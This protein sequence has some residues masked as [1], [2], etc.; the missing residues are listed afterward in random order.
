MADRRRA[1]PL[2]KQLQ[3]IAPL[4][5][6]WAVAGTVVA[7][8]GAQRSIPVQTLFLDPQA[9]GDAPWYAGL[10]SNVGILCWTVAVVAAAGGGWVAAQTNRPSAATFLRSGALAT[11]I[12]LIDDLLL[13]HSTGL[14][15][16]IGTPKLVNIAFVIAPSALWAVTQRN[17]ILR[18]RRTI[19]FAAVLALAV[20]VVADRL[21]RDAASG[22][23]IEDG[24]KLFGIVAWMLYFVLTSRDI[25]R[26][27]I[28]TALLSDRAETAS[29]RPGEQL[30]SRIHTPT[31]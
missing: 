27:T 13:L 7:I 3:P 1:L 28:N 8:A 23:I 6:A 26:S 22:P 16:L 20:S 14:P 15:R 25:A 18:T 30:A 4:L 2:R 17:E 29:P 5:V 12:L 10:L 9:I 11:A 31:G 24:A 21:V 19:L